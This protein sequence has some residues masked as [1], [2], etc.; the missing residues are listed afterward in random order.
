LRAHQIYEID[1]NQHVASDA[2]LKLPTRLRI[3]P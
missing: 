1:L 3:Y 2:K